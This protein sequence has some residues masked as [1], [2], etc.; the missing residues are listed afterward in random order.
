M[1]RLAF[2]YKG[3]NGWCNRFGFWGVTLSEKGAALRII[4]E[5]PTKAELLKMIDEE[6]IA[7]LGKK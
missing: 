7:R 1:D 6:F 3:W 5:I 4:D 2:T